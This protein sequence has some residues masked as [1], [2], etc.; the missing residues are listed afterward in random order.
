M[1]ATGVF[2]PARMYQQA[3]A[4]D[5]LAG[6]RLREGNAEEVLELRARDDERNAVGE[7]DDNGAWNVAD[8]RA[9]SREAH[10][11]EQHAGHHRAHEQAAHAVLRDNAGDHD[12][13][14]TGGPV[15]LH[16]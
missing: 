7:A 1:P 3:E 9:C 10:D 6:D 11:H 12:D 15:N 8:G 14:G 13:E 16:T 2:A 4:R 5:E